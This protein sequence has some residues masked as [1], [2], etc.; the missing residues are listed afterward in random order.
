MHIVHPG[1][2]IDFS[3]VTDSSG[4]TLLPGAPESLDQEYEITVSKSG[5]ETVST[6]PPY[7]ITAFDPID[8]HLS[9]LEGGLAT[10]VITMN[11]L[12]NV[13]IM[14]VDSRGDSIPNALFS[15]SGGRI[16][17]TQGSYPSVVNVYSSIENIETDDSG[18]YEMG[19][20]IPGSYDVIL[21]GATDTTYHL[22][23]IVPGDT[24]SPDRFLVTGG[25]T[26][27]VYAFLV[28]KAL[29][30][31]QVTVKNSVDTSGIP[32]ASVRL[33]NATLGYD[34]T[35]TTTTHGVALF[36]NTSTDLVSDVYTLSVSA[37]GFGSAS[38]SVTINEFTQQEIEL[39]AS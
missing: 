4:N 37:T 20:I 18:E 33:Y 27:V 16:L 39:T 9:V 22:S 12:A 15:I 8:E 32:N 35:V 31:L 13:T 25:S 26:G 34:E 3:T 21:R 28:E 14:S 10:K 5:Y 17:G 19:N 24:L 1:K 29:P 11:P 38:E 36:P 7:P 2:G 23:H 30:S 6:F